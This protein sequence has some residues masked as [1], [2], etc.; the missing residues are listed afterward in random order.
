MRRT[1]TAALVLVMLTATTIARAD[2][3]A[4]GA[5]QP[6][7]PKVGAASWILYDATYG[8]ELASLKPDARRPMAST[9]KI[10]TA[11]VVREHTKLDDWVTVSKRAAAIG[12]AEI[13]LE[14]GERWTIRQLLSAIAVRSANDAAIAVAEHIGGSV[15]G[16]ANFMN[17]KAA[18]MGL[19]N[20]HFVNPHG[21]DSPKHYSSARDLLKM[22]LAV[23]DD[24]YL[25]RAFATRSVTLPPNGKGQ[26]RVAT[27]TNHLLTDY[28][29]AIGI[30]TG[31]TFKAAL[32]LVA[33]AERD[34]RRLVAV[35]MGS[36]GTGGHFK[37]ATKLLNYGFNDFSVIPLIVEGEIYAT[38]RVPEGTGDLRATATVETLAHLAGAGLLDLEVK[39][40][41]PTVQIGDRSQ[42]GLTGPDPPPL[43]SVED[44]LTWV[45]RYWNWLVGRT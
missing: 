38:T 29:G 26:A 41:Q 39:E 3:P 23:L 8:V 22:G 37:D 19:N 40:G 6:P 28:E 17:D 34:G 21:L 11:L 25:A 5:P 1:L 16:F 43:P 4:L 31:F 7:A 45:D 33:A 44:A 14:Q 42:V 36:R 12:E 10:M 35:V 20:T 30:K 2:G 13:G 15:E 9:T 24:P 18:D 27:A 32:V